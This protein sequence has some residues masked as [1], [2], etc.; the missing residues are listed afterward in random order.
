MFELSY[1]HQKAALIRHDKS[2]TGRNTDSPVSRQDRIASAEYKLVVAQLQLARLIGASVEVTY[3][4][5]KDRPPLR[6]TVRGFNLSSATLIVNTGQR[7]GAHVHY[8][9]I[10]QQEVQGQPAMTITPLIELQTDREYKF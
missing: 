7:Q 3:L 8:C 2:I 5:D 6:G 4:Q 9:R 1:G 10:D